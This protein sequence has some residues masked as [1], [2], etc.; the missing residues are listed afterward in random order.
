MPDAEDTAV[1]KLT[2]LYRVV[3]TPAVIQ[4]NEAGEK[5]PALF[6]NMV[7]SDGGMTFCFSPEELT[8]LIAQLTAGKG[9][10]DHTQGQMEAV[11]WESL[12]PDDA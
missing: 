6:V 11:D 2:D 8:R 12:R 4:I 3:T 10:L 7:T 1:P 5:K 9:L